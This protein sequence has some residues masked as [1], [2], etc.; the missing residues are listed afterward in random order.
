MKIEWYEQHT[1]SSKAKIRSEMFSFSRPEQSAN[2][3][4]VSSDNIKLNHQKSLALR[5]ELEDKSIESNKQTDGK[6][7]VDTKIF[8]LIYLSNVLFN[9]TNQWWGERYLSQVTIEKKIYPHS[10]TKIKYI[11]I[12]SLNVKKKCKNKN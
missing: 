1:E 3:S 10:Y 5:Y 12:K 8:Y 4:R 6:T 9:I 11:W 7:L 2:L